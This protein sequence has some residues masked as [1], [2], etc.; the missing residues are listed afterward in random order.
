MKHKTGPTKQLRIEET[1]RP[2]LWRLVDN[3][4]GVV[5]YAEE[6]WESG[7]GYSYVLKRGEF[8]IGPGPKRLD[9]SQGAITSDCVRG[10]RDILDYLYRYD[11]LANC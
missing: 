7:L 11:K 5:G 10:I 3:D 2:G 9:N 1:G 6:R 8:Y 4:G